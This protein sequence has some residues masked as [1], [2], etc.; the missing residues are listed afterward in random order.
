MQESAFYKSESVRFVSSL[1]LDE[2]RNKLFIG[3]S[4]LASLALV[5]LEKEI[6]PKD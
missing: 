1:L 6:N 5:D 2:Q 3:Y 4:V